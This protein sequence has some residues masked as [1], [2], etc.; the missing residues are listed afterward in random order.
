MSDIHGN[1]VALRAVLADAEDRGVDRWWALGD[2]VALGPDPAGVLACLSELPNLQAIGGNTERYVLTGDRP[3]PSYDDAA[4]DRTL[5][6]RLVEVAASFAWTRGAITQ[7]GW[8]DWLTQ[9]PARLRMT[10]PDGTRVL[11]VHASPASDDGAGIDSRISDA[12]L[13]GLL[14]GCDADLVFAG[15]T[16]D[17]TDRT[18]GSV[19]AVN[20]GSVSNPSRADRCATYAILHVED[21]SH[22][23]QHRVVEFDR[24]AALAAIDAAHHPAAEFLKRFLVP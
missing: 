12:A 16:H 21:D 14:D 8:F 5:L 17:L 20:L 19:R 18:V 9:L 23:V 22:R 1:L 7:A 24:A 2:L 3:F 6:P 15:H 4:D 11:G 13:A 10:L